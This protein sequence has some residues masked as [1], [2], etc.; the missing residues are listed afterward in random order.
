MDSKTFN[1][2]KTKFQTTYFKEIKPNL[3]D[4][5]ARRKKYSNT[6]F[7]ITLP[8]GVIISLVALFTL[9]TQND[10]EAIEL[11]F[12]IIAFAIVIN[13]AL[14][15]GLEKKLENDIKNRFMSNICK[16]FENLSW[17]NQ[18]YYNSSE[19]H[20]I[21]LFDYY[22]TERF[23]DIFSGNYKNVKFEIIEANFKHE[24]RAGKRRYEKPVFDGII[25]KIQTPKDFET[26]TLIRPDG[27]FKMPI[28]NLKRTELEDVVFEKKYDVYTD[29]EIESRVIITAA[30]MERLNNIKEV[31][32]A[33]K[34]YC[35]FIKNIAYVG[36]QTERDMFQLCSLRK[37]L[38]ASFFSKMFEE[39]ISIYR[40]IDHLKMSK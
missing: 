32:N 12:C 17:S 1:D 39:I 33:Q 35:C 2:I 37:G 8:L 23:D 29:N 7:Y 20:K 22:N 15:K 10:Q 16:C 40:L 6:Y 26:H 36:L 5:E 34:V 30:F 3:D 21:G 13:I 18:V 9:G 38:D 31:F 27:L 11:C 4:F 14:Y 25:L 19:F 24:I 28:K